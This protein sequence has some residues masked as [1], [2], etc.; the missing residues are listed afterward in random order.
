M[1]NTATATN[2]SVN[3]VDGDRRGVSGRRG[4]SGLGV[5][6]YAVSY[7]QRRDVR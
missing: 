7:V 3:L 4:D 1:D 5:W 2:P 6:Y